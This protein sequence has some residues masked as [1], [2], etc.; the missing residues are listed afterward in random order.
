MDWTGLILGTA[1]M[2]AGGVLKG[3]IGAGAPIIAVPLLALLYDVPFAVAVFLFPN[4]LGNIWQGWIYREHFLSRRFLWRFAGMGALGVLAGSLVLVWLPGE[5]LLAG[6]AALVFLYIGLRMLKPDW[7]LGR[8]A[9]ERFAATAGLLGG[10]MQGAGGVSAPVSV[11]FLNA[12]RLERLEFIATIAVFFTATSLIQLPTLWALG[13]FTPE[14]A[15]LSLAAAVPMFGAMPVGAWLARR[16]S[17]EVFDRAI[18]VLL[19]VIALRLL[20]GAFS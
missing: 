4:I 8:E 20:W 6:L 12:M 18:L 7:I 5:V 9:G 15:A 10:F 16:F 13:V 14:R 19:V 11:T 2:A 1:A 3:A 17:K